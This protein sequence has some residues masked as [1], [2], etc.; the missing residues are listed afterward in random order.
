MAELAKWQDRSPIYDEYLQERHGIELAYRDVAAHRTQTGRV[1][2]P[3]SDI[4][5][6]KLYNM[7]LSANEIHAR[8]SASGKR[9]LV[10]SIRKA[11]N[12]EFGFGP[13]AFEMQI[14]IHLMRRGFDVTCH[15]MEEGGGFDFLA[16]KDGLELEVECKHISGDVGRR[17]HR[18]R[19]LQLGELLFPQVDAVLDQLE[20]GIWVDVI[21]ADRLTGTV[22]DHRTIVSG[23]VAVV[24]RDN[25][26]DNQICQITARR[27]AYNPGHSVFGN[28]QRV[29]TDDIAQFFEVPRDFF[30]S[31][32]LV[33]LRPS[34]AV[35]CINIKCEQGDIVL[36]KIGRRMAE[37]ANRQFTKQRPAMLCAHLSDLKREHLSEIYGDGAGG[38]FRHTIEDV[39]ARRPWLHTVAVTATGSMVLEQERVVG[40]RVMLGLQDGSMLT[41]NMQHPNAN[42]VRLYGLFA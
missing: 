19:L 11:L 32:I 23:I 29:T 1:I 24:R 38:P 13:F 39:M 37:D 34:R 30:N 40:G 36:E 21:L 6:I 41:R 7:A 18:R 35:A 5:N 22:E 42:D 25:E 20:G 28:P 16:I 27:R 14:A 26:V 3:P 17:I 33:L 15:D 10:S 12:S 31:N 2:W 8:L 9:N 4:A